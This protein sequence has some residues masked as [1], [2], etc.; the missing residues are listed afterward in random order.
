ML[1]YRYS[2]LVQDLKEVFLQSL[3]CKVKPVV[4]DPNSVCVE[5]EQGGELGGGGGDRT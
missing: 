3:N 4:G 2:T 1:G 5:G